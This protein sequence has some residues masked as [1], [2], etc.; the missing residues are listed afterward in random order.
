MD[1]GAAPVLCDIGL[2][3]DTAPM[4][5]AK[6]SFLSEI[7]HRYGVALTRFLSG[8]VGSRHEVEDIAQESYLRICALD[9]PRVLDNPRA[10]LFR[11]AANLAID[12]RRKQD[13]R[14]RGLNVGAPDGNADTDVETV[15]AD[16]PTPEDI[17]SARERLAILKR[18]IADLPKKCRAVFVLHRFHGL[19]HKQ[20]AAQ[21]AITVA[22]VE[23]HIM[24]ALDRC[25]RALQH[26][27]KP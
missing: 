1:D 12:H 26:R 15:A 6:A 8:R 11:T 7:Y 16:A 2:E 9:D 23:K 21:Q 10:F 25:E 22:A 24:R 5:D 17:A 18:C 27:D 20:I 4:A 13:V 14:R 19:S 3:R